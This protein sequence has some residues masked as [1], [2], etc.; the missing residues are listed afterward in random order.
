MILIDVAKNGDANGIREVLEASFPTH[1]EAD[2]V[3]AIVASEH[4]VS[5]LALVAKDGA[6]VVGYSL[7]SE[8]FVGTERILVLAPVAVKPEWQSRGIG[9]QLIEAGIAKAK[10]MDYSCISVLG[11]EMYY[12]RFGFEL[13]KNYQIT[14]PF[15]VPDVNFMVYPLGEAIPSGVVRYPASF[16]IV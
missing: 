15:D 16:D 4:Y 3:E 12:P 10:T 7:L 2:L 5:E 6:E 9:A 11:H 8:C 14:A 13:A 1:A